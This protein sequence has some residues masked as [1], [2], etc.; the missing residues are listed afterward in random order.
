[1]IN[2]F[3]SIGTRVEV[4]ATE[5]DFL[6]AELAVVASETTASVRLHAID[7]CAIVLAFVILTIVDIDF[8]SRAFVARQ[9]VT[10]ETAL[11]EN[12]TSAIIPARI[13]V[14]SI[15]H[16]L[17][18]QTVVARGTATFVLLFRLH[19][20]FRIILAWECEAGITFRQNLVTDFLFA[21][22]LIRWCRE[23]KF[24]FHP[25]W[26]GASCNARLDIIQFHPFREPF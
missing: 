11:L 15:N 1:M 12:T 2:A 21:E 6:L 5:L 4:R 24:V 26:L 19:D 25:F 14:A 22:E 13:A 18:V 8:A 9:A 3:R 10:A 7:T 16:V 20:T 23:N 17:A